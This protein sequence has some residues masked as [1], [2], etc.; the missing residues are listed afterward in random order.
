MDRGQELNCLLVFWGDDVVYLL[1]HSPNLQQMPT[2]PW[3]SQWFNKFSQRFT[4]SLW[5]VLFVSIK[6][7]SW[8]EF[9]RTRYV[10]NPMI[11][12]VKCV[13]QEKGV[14]IMC[15]LVC[16]CEVCFGVCFVE[17]PCCVLTCELTAV[18]VACIHDNSL[19]TD[20]SF[21]GL[22]LSLCSGQCS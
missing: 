3:F 11:Y 2:L 12:K 20:L 18:S 13:V 8:S 22:V 17:G 1:S 21:W 16:L 6:Q 15:T 9:S 10:I 5:W 7:W 4:L 14:R 19:C